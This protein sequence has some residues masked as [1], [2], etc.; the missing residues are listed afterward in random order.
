MTLASSYYPDDRVTL[1]ELGLRDGLQLTESYPSTARKLEWIEIANRA[2]VRHIEVGSFLPIHRFPQ[3]ADISELIGHMDTLE[4]CISSALT[5]NER[6][7]DDALS[8][9]VRE[10]VV[11]VSATE[12]HS[13]ANIRKTRKQALDLVRYADHARKRD[14]DK[15]P[16]LTAAISVAFGCS[17][18]GEVA[19]DEVRRLAAECVE[20][21]ADAVAVA[22]TVG[23]A[24]PRQVGD[25]CRTLGPELA[26]APVIIHLH[27]TR[28]TGIANAFAALEA[29]VRV[30]DGTIG[31]L[32]G[33]PFAPGATGN[34]VF[35]DLVF[36]CE[37][38]GFRTGIDIN[39]LMGIRSIIGDCM[40]E[41]ALYGAIGR[42]G[43]PANISWAS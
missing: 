24:G 35:E 27:D 8:T 5:L 25:L 41:E 37:R 23:Y 3:F 26:P 20:S 11:T 9:S 18:A 7:V 6:A 30:L 32:G 28:G 21:G 33:C 36:L 13:L 12:E 2:G 10:I 38:S 17:I 19:A 40:P 16:L 1:R 31:G 29:G 14:V 34:V 15:R 22:D 42:A 39:V 43:P 4:G